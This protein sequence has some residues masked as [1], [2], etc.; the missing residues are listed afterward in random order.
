M[1]RPL[2]GVRVLD[3]TRVVSGPFA[4]RMLSDLG[5]D[6]V[7]IEPPEG[8]VTRNWGDKRNGVAGYY[9]QQN[10]GKRNICVDLRAPG[11]V[12][13]ILDLVAKA[14]IVLENFRA[15]VM[16]RLGLGWDVLQGVNTRLVMC[17]ISGF[18]QTG[19]EAGRAAYAP[20]IEAETGVVHRQSRFDSAAPTDPMVSIADFNAGLHAIVAMLAALRL[21]DRTGM[22]TAIDISMFETMLATDDYLHHAIDGSELIRLGGEY[23]SLADGGHILIAGNL[24]AVWRSLTDAHGLIDPSESGCDLDTKVAN[25]RAAVARWVH[26]FPDRATLTVSLNAASLAHGYLTSP[27]EAIAS[28]TAIA[29][30]VIAQVDDRGGGLR[31]VVQSP[32][33]F[34]NAESGVRR[35]AAHRGEQNAEVL[36]D[37]LG[38]SPHEIATLVADGVLLS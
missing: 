9:Q 17:S 27:E 36:G 35:G 18:G 23:W 34:S 38:S 33:R 7:K 24:R 10:A 32:Y 21:V 5:A 6:V 26:E 28:P 12:P 1:V 2:D 13:M 20:V 16:D 22:G 30:G 37:W 14:D 8:D 15:G 19:P 4:G 31:G 3:F 25:R 11:A 29:R